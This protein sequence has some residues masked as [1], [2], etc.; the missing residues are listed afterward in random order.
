MCWPSAQRVCRQF[1][2]SWVHWKQ[3]MYT[4]YSTRIHLCPEL[5]RRKQGSSTCVVNTFFR[6]APETVILPFIG[7]SKGMSVQT[8]PYSLQ[9]VLKLLA[10]PYDTSSLNCGRRRTSAKITVVICSDEVRAHFLLSLL[11]LTASW[12]PCS[13]GRTF[14]QESQVSGP[15]CKKSG[16]EAD[17][18]TLA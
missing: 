5:L 16:F 10:I 18:E 15:F 6:D 1:S 14:V 12:N 8:H 4:L 9:A 13:A 11:S 2:A 3:Y 7:D 17:V